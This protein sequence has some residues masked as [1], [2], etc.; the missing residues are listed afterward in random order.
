MADYQNLTKVACDLECPSCGKRTWAIFDALVGGGR[1]PRT[2]VACMVC[3]TPLIIEAD[4]EVF[5]EVRN[6]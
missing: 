4:L 1:V 5:V 6:G 3:S 2:N